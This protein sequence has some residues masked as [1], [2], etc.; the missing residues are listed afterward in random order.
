MLKSVIVIVLTAFTVGLL[1]ET[2]V[3]IVQ[4]VQ[5][6]APDLHGAIELGVS[7]LVVVAVFYVSVIK[8]V[9]RRW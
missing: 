5:G 3:A 7:W 8:A 4:G 9:F 6:I 1:A 2:A